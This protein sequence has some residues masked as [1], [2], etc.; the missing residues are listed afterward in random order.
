MPC[1]VFTLQEAPLAPAGNNPQA[2]NPVGGGTGWP[3]CASRFWPRTKPA[4]RRW[5]KCSWTFFC[6]G[7]A[8]RTKRLESPPVGYYGRGGSFPNRLYTCRR[9][10]AAGG[11]RFPLIGRARRRQ[12]LKRGSGA[13]CRAN[14]FTMAAVR[15]RTIGNV[16]A[17]GAT[18]EPPARPRQKCPGP[19]SPARARGCK[20]R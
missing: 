4:E 18:R 14:R 8:A 20:T 3:A 19:H 12:K 6:A 7:R 10:T 9:A 13:N 15:E 5:A 2:P 17:T 11:L 1:R 16:P